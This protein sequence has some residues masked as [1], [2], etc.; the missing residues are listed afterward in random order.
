V[1]LHV[2]IKKCKFKVMSTKYLSFI[3][4]ARKGTKI[5]LDKV[6]AIKD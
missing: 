2:D 4:I 5:D 1:G 6:K 3:I